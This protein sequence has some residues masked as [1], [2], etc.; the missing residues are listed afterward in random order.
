[1]LSLKT[2]R[3]FAVIVGPKGKVVEVLA[4]HER[5]KVF[6]EEDPELRT[7]LEKYGTITQSDDPERLV[8]SFTLNEG[9]TLR[10]V[11]GSLKRG[12]EQ[13]CSQR[14]GK[15][16]SGKSFWTAAYVAAYHHRYPQNRIFYVS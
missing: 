6:L 11:P 2:G 10:A 13:S 4:I 5:D 14:C 8:T 16:G 3:E 7:T 15:A 9:Y 1:M 12:N